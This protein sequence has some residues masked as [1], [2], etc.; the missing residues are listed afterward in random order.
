MKQIRKYTEVNELNKILHS[1]LRPL[2]IRLAEKERGIASGSIPRVLLMMMAANVVNYLRRTK[3]IAET[4]ISL[5]KQE[6]LRLQSQLEVRELTLLRESNVQ[7]REENR[8]NFE[9]C[10]KLREELQNVRIET[11]NLEKLLRDRDTALEGYRKEIEI[12][13]MEKVHLEK[14]IDE[15]V[16]KCKNV[17]LD[18]YNRL[19]ESF[20]QMQVNLRERDSQLEE[21]KKLLSEKQDAIS[22]L[23]RDLARSRTELN[24]RETRINEILQAEA[25]LKS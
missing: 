15:L 25:S 13:K 7:L 16:E 1:D 8:H 12:L 10:Q 20:Q 23:E 18:D 3:E 5:L 9:E 6:K 4:E 14:R 22:V 21:T 17:D 24:E 19:K 2:H 11:E